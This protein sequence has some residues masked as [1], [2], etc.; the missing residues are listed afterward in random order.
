MN[1]NDIVK[2]EKDGNQINRNFW[3]LLVGKVVSQLGSG[4]FN[5]A[6]PWYILS[7]TGKVIAMSTYLVI[8]N[9]SCGVALLLSGR[10]IDSWRKEKVMYLSDYSKGLYI[11]FLFL[12]IYLDLSY[13]FI[14]IYL[15]AVILNICS[16]LFNPA[17]MSIIPAIIEEEKLVKANSVL[18]I[19]DNTIAVMGM[20]MGVAVYE[21]L[22]IKLVFL[23]TG[24]SYLVSA[25]FEMFIRTN[26]FVKTDKKSVNKIGIMS[27]LRYLYHTKK[28]LFIIIFA[29]VWNYIYISIFSVYVPF[30]FNMV[31]KSSISTVAVIHMV[32]AIGLILGA[33][34]SSK[35]NISN[36]IY[37][38]LSK[39]VFLQMPVLILLP[40]VL[41]LDEV[42]I[43][44]RLF[45]VIA[46]IIIFFVM[47]ITIAVVN[48][49]VCFII[50][51]ETD[52]NFIGRVNSYKSLGS[53]ISMALGLLVGG[54]LIER[55]NIILVFGINSVL[56]VFLA[57][58]MFKQ[59]YKKNIEISLS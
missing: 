4:I 22:G 6:L 21:I 24:I 41:L 8:A 56:F 47:G 51:S 2:A 50:Q 5:T 7:V 25:F 59:F 49:N 16:A 31:Y 55:I 58:F 17:S 43:H 19:I 12:T 46:Y 1:Y 28:I 32:E 37:K 14:W 26:N 53:M 57:L 33:T 13:K 3:L 27:G 39:V 9:L 18:S 40:V 45:V 20:A 35:I 23:I 10:L 42:F 38:N 44:S 48:I 36:N 15:G 54:I 11:L 29:L 34:L 30:I 52:P